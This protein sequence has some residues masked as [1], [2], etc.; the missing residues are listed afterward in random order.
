ML[1][2]D[3]E[4]VEGMRLKRDE[5]LA[6]I[7]GTEAIIMHIYERGEI[8]PGEI[9]MHLSDLEIFRGQAYFAEVVVSLLETGKLPEREITEPVRRNGEI[10]D[11]MI[12]RAR[13]YP[14]EKLVDVKRG[15]RINCINPAHEDRRPSMDIRNGFVYCYSCHWSGDAIRV[16][17]Q[18][19]NIN[20]V[21]AVRYLN[22]R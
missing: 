9:G 17:M 5:L 19:H 6:E 12:E 13:A 21:E 15:G 18:I 2:S 1:P 22:G 20:F 3:V 14:I 16:V 4:Y 7:G 10:T 8:F 11:L